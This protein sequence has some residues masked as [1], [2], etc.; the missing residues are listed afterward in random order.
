MVW[1]WLLFPLVLLGAAFALWRAA[2]LLTVERR[3]L[4]AEIDALSPLSEAARSLPGYRE[5]H[6]AIGREQVDR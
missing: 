1:L 4:Q 6:R 3:A 5:R 2:G